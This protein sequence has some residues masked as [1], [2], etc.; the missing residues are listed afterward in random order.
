LLTHGARRPWETYEEQTITSS[1]E[2]RGKS[3]VVQSFSSRVK[4]LRAL[5]P[6]SIWS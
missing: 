1:Q 2:R 4:A 5:S 3:R 6:T